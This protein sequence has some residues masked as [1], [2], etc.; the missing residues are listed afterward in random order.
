VRSKRNAIVC[1]LLVVGLFEVYLVVAAQAPWPP[2]PIRRPS[3]PALVQR[4]AHVQPEVAARPAALPPIVNVPSINA[5]VAPAATVKQAAA[6]V[7]APD[8]AAPPLPAFPELPKAEAPVA[9]PM[10]LPPVTDVPPVS[11]GLAAPAPLLTPQAP[12][13]AVTDGGPPLTPPTATLAPTAPAPTLPLTPPTALTPVAPAPTL[14]LTPPTAA[15]TPMQAR[16]PASAPPAIQPITPPAQAPISAAVVPTEPRP[17]EFVRVRPQAAAPLLT[18][19]GPSVSPPAPQA[20]APLLT[21]PRPLV[22]PPAPPVAE[23]I[24][25]VL[26]PA[27]VDSEPRWIALPRLAPGE[28]AAVS[29]AAAGWTYQTPRL[30]VEKRGPAA[31]QAGETVIY[32]LTV[33]N[34]GDERVHDVQV[35]EALPAQALPQAAEPAA[36][37]RDSRV[38]WQLAGLGPREEQTLV[39]SV[40]A[41]TALQVGNTTTLTFKS[42]LNRSAAETAA[43]QGG[44]KILVRM[45]APA[46]VAQGAPAVFKITFINTSQEPIRDLKLF[47]SLPEGLAHPAGTSLEA[48]LEALAPGTSRT[49]TMTATAVRAG[50]HTVSV[51]LIS[52]TAGTTEAQATVVVGAGGLSLHQVPASPLKTGKMDMISF[53]VGNQTDRPLQQISVVYVL[54]EN[55]DFVDASNRGL[56]QAN[57]RTVY[58][59]LELPPGKAQQVAIK[60]LPRQAG[61]YAGE[62]TA[63]GPGVG[64]AKAPVT[65]TVSGDTAGAAEAAQPDGE[66]GSSARGTWSSRWSPLAWFKGKR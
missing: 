63:Q 7:E 54:P 30:L 27:P 31:V 3:E 48:D 13:P 43:P 5:A 14:P 66:A 49:E 8:G 37:M 61:A 4:A 36:T 21:P 33:R 41:T 23:S 44:A 47:G 18:P 22:S 19:P 24:H 28:G 26:T 42:P 1:L 52:A 29:S 10:Q 2:P 35:E 55:L 58:W 15:V 65:V 45:Q 56:Y 53:E 60:L 6:Q 20:T 16:P 40:K 64:E 11:S 12:L 25:R 32:A 62:V 57:S 50:R 39:L 46:Q 9:K 17:R 59:L 51:K 34:P 38:R